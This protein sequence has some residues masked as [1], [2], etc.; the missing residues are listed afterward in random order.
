MN[1]QQMRVQVIVC[2]PPFSSLE[3]AAVPLNVFLPTK[4]DQVEGT[5]KGTEG[6]THTVLHHTMLPS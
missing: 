5:R 2:L 6:V 4:T 1:E 3:K